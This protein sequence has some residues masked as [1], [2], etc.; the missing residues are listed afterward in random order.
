MITSAAEALDLHENMAKDLWRHALK[1]DPAVQFMQQLL[2]EEKG[3][4]GPV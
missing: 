1:G 3:P 4:T 2:I